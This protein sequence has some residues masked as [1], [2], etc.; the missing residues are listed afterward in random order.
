MG[1]SHRGLLRLDL[2][3]VPAADAPEDQ[4]REEGDR[5]EPGDAALPERHDDERG[6]HRSHRGAKTAAEL[7]YR[8]RKAV[9]AAGGQPRDARRLRMKHRRAET[10]ERGANGEKGELGG[11]PGGKKT[12]KG[13]GQADRKRIR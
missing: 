10:D 13:R 7:E 3:F 6:Q 4:D 5:G 1:L 9:A 2:R 11:G 8:L 12:E